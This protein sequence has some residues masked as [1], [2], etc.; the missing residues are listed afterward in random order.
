MTTTKTAKKKSSAF[1]ELSRTDE[2]HSSSQWNEF[3]A[4]RWLAT[5]VD[6]IKTVDLMFL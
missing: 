6:G 1:E 5:K 4:H 2:A 3:E